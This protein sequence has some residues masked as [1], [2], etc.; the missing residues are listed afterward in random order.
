ME[1]LQNKIISKNPKKLTLIEIDKDL[2]QILKEKFK[3]QQTY[4]C[5]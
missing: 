4:K 2:I 1:N 3:I 5:Y